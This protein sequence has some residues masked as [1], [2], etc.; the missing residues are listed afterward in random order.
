MTRGMEDNGIRLDPALQAVADAVTGAG[1]QPMVELSPDDARQRVRA[2]AASCAP[3]PEMESVTTHAVGDHVTVRIYR[4]RSVTS[5]STIVHLHG[6]G[7]VTG[8]LD[9]A[10]AICRTFAEAAGAAVVSV[11]YRLAPEHR[12]P[13]AVEDAMAVLRWVAAGSEGLGRRIVVTGD[14]AGGNLA[15]VCAI[16]ARDDT[17]IDLA[18]QVLIYPV[19][20]TDLDRASYAANSGVFLGAREMRWFLGHYCPEAAD[21]TSP[22]IAPIRAVDLSGLAPAVVVVGGHDPLF[23]EGVEYAERLA[24]SGV[25][26]DLLR[27]P[28]LPHGFLQFTAVSAAAAEAAAEIVAAVSRVVDSADVQDVSGKGGVHA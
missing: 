21:R 28:A 13:V 26:V 11:D 4:P 5:A 27:Y 14:S 19:V 17:G 12:F 20:D 7:W 2:A 6:G 24:A 25:R 16:Q 10:D 9:Y 1:L 8:D 18:G 15:A 3:G 22:M 23:D